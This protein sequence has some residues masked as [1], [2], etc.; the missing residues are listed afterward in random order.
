MTVCFFGTGPKVPHLL[1]RQEQVGLDDRRLL[2]AERAGTLSKGAQLR[3]HP[4]GFF[5]GKGKVAD[6]LHLDLIAIAIRNKLGHRIGQ[7]YFGV[8][9]FLG[10]QRTSCMLTGSINRDRRIRTRTRLPVQCI[11]KHFPQ[12]HVEYTILGDETDSSLLYNHETSGT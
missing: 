4:Q 7:H 10:I 1:D 9:Q 6:L 2:R 11:I 12:N 3:H 5:L 8:V